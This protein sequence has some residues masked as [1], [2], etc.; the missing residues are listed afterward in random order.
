M[1]LTD[2]TLFYKSNPNVHVE[3]QFGEIIVDVKKPKLLLVPSAK[4]LFTPPNELNPITI[5]HFKCYDVKESKD[6]PKF[7]KRIVSLCDP[8]FDITKDF[9]VKKPKMLCT[10]VEKQVDN[11]D[12]TVE[13][14]P[15]QNPENHLMC[16]DI[17]KMKG[18][19][20][21]EKRNVFTDNQFGPE[22]LEVKKVKQLCLPSSV[23]CTSSTTTSSCNN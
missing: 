21:F 18:E 8:N 13:I 17:K 10:P 22:D 11:A 23:F 6:T 3:N 16:Y 2:S 14:T 9:E 7:V 19:P 15:I 20:K 5:N 12:G 4:D 1:A